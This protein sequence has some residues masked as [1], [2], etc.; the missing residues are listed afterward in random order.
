[1]VPP[2]LGSP[3]LLGAGSPVLGTNPADMLAVQLAAHRHA[4]TLEWSQD[5]LTPVPDIMAP[6][7]TPPWW[8]AHK[9]HGL[10]YNGMVRGDHRGTMIFASSLCTDSVAEAMEIM[11]Y[12]DDVAAY[13]KS[14]RARRSTPS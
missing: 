10:F 7:D 9:K 2:L 1:M 12:F 13:I 11:D 5:K 8:R 6:V 14:L 4:D 3:L